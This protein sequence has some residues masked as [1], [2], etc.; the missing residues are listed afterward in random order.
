[1]YVSVVEYSFNIF[2]ILLSTPIFPRPMAVGIFYFLIEFL[3][4]LV[5]EVKIK[6]I[7]A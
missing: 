5:E 1:M 3:I 2:T 7:L 4:G 6:G